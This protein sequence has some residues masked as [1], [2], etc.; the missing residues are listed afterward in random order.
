MKPIRMTE[1]TR[2]LGAPGDWN[3]KAGECQTLD[4]YDY[5][6]HN[7]NIMAS[8]WMPDEEELHALRNGAI[9]YLHIHGKAHPVVSLSVQGI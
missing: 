8:A 2:S 5:E 7:G 1:A 9:L 4:I 3:D 6:G